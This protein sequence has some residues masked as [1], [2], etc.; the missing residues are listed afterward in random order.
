MLN[1]LPRGGY[2]RRMT[3][4]RTSEADRDEF[5]VPVAVSKNL[6]W[7]WGRFSKEPVDVHFLSGNH[8]T[9]M[10]EPNIQ[11]LAEQLKACIEQAQKV[12]N[13]SLIETC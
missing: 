7:G 2:S 1:Y 13:L 3:F 12:Q 8:F 11:V 10:T 4:F 6:A 5:G 9:M